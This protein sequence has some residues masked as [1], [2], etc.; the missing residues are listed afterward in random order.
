MA[1]S[2]FPF[3]MGLCLS[4]PN[5]C[6]SGSLYLSKHPRK[7]HRNFLKQA[8]LIVTVSTEILLV[9]IYLSHNNVGQSWGSLCS[10]NSGIWL[11]NHPRSGL[12]IRPGYDLHHMGLEALPWRG[13]SQPPLPKNIVLICLTRC[14]HLK[15]F[16]QLAEL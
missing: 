8:L 9:Q 1:L 2:P 4:S 10:P 15:P 5:D 12:C 11:W 6:H 7:G 16:Q 14:K 3:V 13:L